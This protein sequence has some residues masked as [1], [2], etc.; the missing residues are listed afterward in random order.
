MSDDAFH[1]LGRYYDALMSE[2]NYDR[3]V[4][5]GSYLRDL[6]G[7]PDPA[8]LDIA[9]GTGR[10][11]HAVLQQGWNSIGIDLSASMLRSA[12]VG[13]YPATVAAADM[14]ALPFEERFDFVTCL[15]D[16]LNFVIELDA[17]RRAMREAYRVLRPGGIF[18]FDTI[19]ERMITEHFADRTWREKHGKMRAE[20]QGFWVPDTGMADLRIR[21]NR[22]PYSLIRER[23]YS[24]AAI[25]G[26]L[27]DAGFEVI[28][29]LDAENWNAP[30]YQTLRIDWI[31]VKPPMQS[32]LAQFAAIEESVQ[33][34]LQQ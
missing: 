25:R 10:F 19:T 5:V 26:A 23:I 1:D 7:R 17:V 12:V 2:I 4:V 15:F 13:P 9:C 27:V 21:I 32:P 3:W 29:Y 8:H 14:T 16:S 6:T 34:I 18:Y 24:D 30:A 20:W 22:G 28:G 33:R 31:A 11:L